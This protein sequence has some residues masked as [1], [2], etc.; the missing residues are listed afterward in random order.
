MDD[1]TI[2]LEE[3]QM[4]EKAI[5]DSQMGNRFA[6]LTGQVS[7]CGDATGILAT[8]VGELQDQEDELN[9]V[10]DTQNQI[11]DE[12]KKQ[13]KSMLKAQEI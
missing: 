4:A 6:V 10:I 9:G 8:S 3:Y 12:M 11:L 1:G 2:T 7:Q 5:S 13:K